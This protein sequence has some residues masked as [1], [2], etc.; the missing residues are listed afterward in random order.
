VKSLHSLE[1]DAIC[2]LY[3]CEQSIMQFMCTNSD[4]LGFRVKG[5]ESDRVTIVMIKIKIEVNV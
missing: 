2:F 4:K 5:R 3:S 1:L